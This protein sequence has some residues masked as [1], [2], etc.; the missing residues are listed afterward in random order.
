MWSFKSLSLTDF[1]RLLIESFLLFD[2][3]QMLLDCCSQIFILDF[4]QLLNNSVS[5]VGDVQVSRCPD[6]LF[7]YLLIE[8]L[9]SR[10][11]RQDAFGSNKYLVIGLLC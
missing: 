6:G 4:F 8:Q 7:Q 5:I 11:V 3:E 10:I 9:G 1:S 2:T